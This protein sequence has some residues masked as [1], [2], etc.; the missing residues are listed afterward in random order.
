MGT[1]KIADGTT[2]RA[3]EILG[4]AFFYIDIKLDPLYNN[5]SF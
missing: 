2:E 1:E 3:L 5:L 4:A